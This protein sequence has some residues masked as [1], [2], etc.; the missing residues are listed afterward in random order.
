M[1]QRERLSEHFPNIKPAFLL[2]YINN[3]QSIMTAS[4]AG[5][6]LGLFIHWKRHYS[7]FQRILTRICF[8]LIEVR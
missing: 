6:V 4:S 1:N 7:I 5:V 2:H 8:I 3:F